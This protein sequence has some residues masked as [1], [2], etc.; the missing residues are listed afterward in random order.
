VSHMDLPSFRLHPLNG[1]LKGFW[2]VTVGANWRHF[3]PFLK[4]MPR[5][6]IMSIITREGE[7]PHD[8]EKP[9]PPWRC[10]LAPVH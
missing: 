7:R 6:L 8:D 5:T 2:A 9:T 10:R 1:Q 4:G 3:S